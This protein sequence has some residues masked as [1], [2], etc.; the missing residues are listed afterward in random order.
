[1]AAPFSFLLLARPGRSGE[2]PARQA[3]G[4]LN[5]PALQ[6]RPGECAKTN[7]QTTPRC[8]C[9]VPPLRPAPAGLFSPPAFA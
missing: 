3:T 4:R 9:S 8:A 5:Y 1:M 7:R 6:V 2:W